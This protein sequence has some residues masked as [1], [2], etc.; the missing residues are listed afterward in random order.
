MTREENVVRTP[1]KCWPE[2]RFV[3]SRI[4]IVGAVLFVPVMLAVSAP[5]PVNTL[6]AQVWGKSYQGPFL[7]LVQGRFD[8]KPLEE[9]LKELAEQSEQTILLDAKVGDKG[10]TA[11]TAKLMNTPL[12]TAVTL[13]ADMAELQ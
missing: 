4:A 13:L 10:K 8:K 3:M 5:A 6:R 1:A 11:V 12:D 9:V 7:P 2:W